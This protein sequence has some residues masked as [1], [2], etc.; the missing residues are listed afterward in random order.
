MFFHDRYNIK[1]IP[2]D[3]SQSPECYCS[4]F[5]NY[6]RLISDILFN[7]DYYRFI[8]QRLKYSNRTYIYQYSQRTAQ[9]HPTPCNDYLHK[10]DLVGHFAELEYTWG[11][12][13]LPEFTNST[14]NIIPF[15]KYIRYELNTTVNPNV[16][17][18]YTDEQ[19]QFSR[20]LVEQWSSFVKYGQ[21]RSSVFKNKWPP[22]S[23]MSTASVMHLQVNRS[24]VTKLSVPISVQFWK[25][26]CSKTDENH[27]TT[28]RKSNQSSVYQISYTLFICSLLFYKVL[29]LINSFK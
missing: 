3:C 26:E 14:H 1:D 29:S 28:A 2:H 9:E 27:P 12:P 17:H 24:E 8:E 22:I 5:Y 21:P 4:I 25:N 10:R 16:T 19:I 20:Q 15:I 6:S 7:N 18:V 11:T 13:L 23:N